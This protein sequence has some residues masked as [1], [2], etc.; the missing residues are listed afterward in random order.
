MI[1]NLYITCYITSFMCYIESTYNILYNMKCY[2]TQASV[3]YNEGVMYHC[4]CYI[5]PTNLPAARLIRS[6]RYAI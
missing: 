4:P 6:I 2:I 1:Y 3:S 5:T